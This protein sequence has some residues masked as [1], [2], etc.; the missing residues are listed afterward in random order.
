MPRGRQTA[1]TITLTADERQTL[2]AW[3]RST[4][5]PAA[6][7][8]RGRMLLL[9]ADGRSLTEI[10]AMVGS[11]RRFV[12]KW[13]RR[14]QAHGLAGL[15]DTRGRYRRRVRTTPAQGTRGQPESEGRRAP[16]GVARTSCEMV[17]MSRGRNTALTLTLTAEDHHALRAWQRSAQI[18]ARQARRGRVLVLLA[19]GMTVTAVAQRVGVT[20][21]SVSLW[22][23]RFLQDGLEGLADKPGRRRRPVSRQ[24]DR[25]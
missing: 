23:Q 11:S 3:Q 21:R 7:A 17:G 22:A 12:Y 16:A 10:A 15:A 14:F 24:Q 19:E 6:R 5:I 2:L 9:L 18:P 20:R 1:L 25:T 8:R 13:V 4:T